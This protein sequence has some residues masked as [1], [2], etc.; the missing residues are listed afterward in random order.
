[1]CVHIFLKLINVGMIAL[2]ELLLLSKG[3][4][5]CCFVFCFCLHVYLFFFFAH[6]QFIIGL[7]LGLMSKHM[8]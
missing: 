8:N 7:A 1:M 5:L 4:K 3:L 2:T 6:V